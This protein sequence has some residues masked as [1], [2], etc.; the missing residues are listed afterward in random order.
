MKNDS[1]DNG[2]NR[3]SVMIFTHLQ[4]TASWPWTLPPCQHCWAYNSMSRNWIVKSLR[5][6]HPNETRRVSTACYVC[7]S[8][9]LCV[10]AHCVVYICTACS[11]CKTRLC[12]LSAYIIQYHGQAKNSTYIPRSSLGRRRRSRGRCAFR[13]LPGFSG[14]AQSCFSVQLFLHGFRNRLLLHINRGMLTEECS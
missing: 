9:V 1:I 13:R 5:V 2:V 11:V 3:Q 7:M 10:Y 12:T 8:S 6:C 4:V 14:S